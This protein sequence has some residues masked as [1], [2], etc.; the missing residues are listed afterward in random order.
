VTRG[1]QAP[2]RPSP[3][4]LRALA[5]NPWMPAIALAAFALALGAILMHYGLHLWTHSYDEDTYRHAG[6]ATAR[7]LPQSLWSMDLSDRGLQRLETW[8]FAAALE[9]LGTPDGFRAVRVVNTVCFCSTA[10]P[11]WFWGR[12]LGLTP[13]WAA[14]TAALAISVPWAT[15]TATFL[16]E[17]V[18]YPAVTWGLYGIWSAAVRPS[19]RTVLLVALGLAIA[20]LS[21]T[22]MIVLPGV[23]LVVALAVLLRYDAAAAW[24]RRRALTPRQLVPAGAVLAL[25]V[26]GLALFLFDRHALDPLTGRYGASTAILPERIPEV[27]RVSLARV[28]SGVGIVPGIVGIA[29]MVEA[30]VRPARR[31]S[32]ALAVLAVMT[33]VLVVYSAL[34]AGPDERYLMYL[35]PVLLLAAAVAVQCREVHVAVLGAATALVLW[36]FAGAPWNADGTP[37]SYMVAAAETFHA[38]V[39]LLGVGSRLAPGGLSY[40]ALLALGI[41]VAMAAV[42]VAVRAAGRPWAR[43]LGGALLAGIAVVQ[44]VQLVYDDR[45]FTTDAA[46]GPAPLED[47][48]WVDRAAG[49]DH[50]IGLFLPPNTTD[51][52][53]QEAWRETA[54]WN[55]SVTRLVVAP[56]ATPLPPYNV[57]TIESVGLDTETG[58]LAGATALPRWLLEPQ[59]APLAPLYG[60]VVAAAGYEPLN[61]VRMRRAAVRWLVT[62]TDPLGWTPP[63]QDARI[64]VFFPADRGSCLDVQLD[65]PPGVQGTHAVTLRSAG[66]TRRKPLAEGLAAT[67][68]FVALR[69]ATADRFAD[70]RVRVDGGTTPPTGVSVGGRISIVARKACPA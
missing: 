4:A 24:R 18:A 60:D 1:V 15:V 67:F 7:E 56:G 61:L 51:L 27:T 21:R 6:I 43:W 47:R 5:R 48:A 2:S 26:A 57:S 49:T 44:L 55:L 8:V 42:A 65:P 52:G 54:F 68:R 50:G 19:P 11:V 29:W 30:L 40:E 58:R 16:T 14:F 3:T 12:R 10:V 62:G 46:W 36:L 39:L 17:N 70:V 13:W 64:R 53:L 69:Q 32:F 23:F 66:R 25:G 9:P 20:M 37:F 33:T 34:R 41:I 28:V 31:A 59:L 63:D 45:R 22:V 38:R 35:A